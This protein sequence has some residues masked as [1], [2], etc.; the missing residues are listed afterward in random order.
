VDGGDLAIVRAAQALAVEG[1]VLAQLGAAL[2]DPVAQEGFEGVDVE[3]SKDAA[4]GRGA[5]RLSASESEGVG[6][7]S[8]VIA[9][10][11]GDALERGAAGENRHD[12]QAP[13]G[14]PIVDATFG[15]A[16]IGNAVEH[17]DK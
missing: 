3:A 10:E 16:G 9:S 14:S 11:W 6:Q 2:E 8:S 7:G 1:E 12:R 13:Q 4:V 17:F 15:L 5:G